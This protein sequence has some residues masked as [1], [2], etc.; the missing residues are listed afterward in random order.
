MCIRDSKTRAPFW[1]QVEYAGAAGSETSWV[2][3]KSSD[4]ALADRWSRRDAAE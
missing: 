1:K 2:A 4:D 3:A